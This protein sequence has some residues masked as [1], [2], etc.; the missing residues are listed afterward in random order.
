MQ[1]YTIAADFVAE[2]VSVLRRSGFK[3]TI[4]FEMAEWV[5]FL[6]RHGAFANPTFDPRECEITPYTG[7]WIGIYDDRGL[8][9]VN[10]AR[11]F[12]SGDFRRDY[13]L[14]G[15]IHY[16]NPPAGFEPEL[17]TGE[18]EGMLWDGMVG[19]SG[20]IW[21]HP[22]A[23]KQGLPWLMPRIC[24]ALAIQ[25]WNIDR[26]TCLILDGLKKAGFSSKVYG[27]PEGWPIFEGF[28]PCTQA[29][30]RVHF[31]H[32]ERPAIV[33]QL[34]ADLADFRDKGDQQLVDLATVI[35]KRE[36]QAAIVDTK[37]VLKGD[38]RG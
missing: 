36:D 7:F 13:L 30:S 9:S 21:V 34:A 6:E 31:L 35:G 3:F 37:V 24:R 16:D 4:N 29:E 28:H 26:H 10:A 23:R 17:F 8:C 18:T 1:D 12:R 25:Q 27:Y 33:A 2:A 32:I 15:K 38:N 11:L 14:T 19:H 5:D 20:G 22:R